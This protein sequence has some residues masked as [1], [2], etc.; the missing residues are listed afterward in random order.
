MLRIAVGFAV[1][2]I[3]WS[4]FIHMLGYFS[5]RDFWF[6]YVDS[7]KAASIYIK[8]QRRGPW[9]SLSALYFPLEG[10]NY[11]AFFYHSTKFCFTWKFYWGDILLKYLDEK[12]GD[13]FQSPEKHTRNAPFDNY[14]TLTSMFWIC[15]L[16]SSLMSNQIWR[17][18]CL[19]NYF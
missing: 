10:S 2:W 7:E 16:A 8:V 14:F 4:I 6:K 9:W 19:Y 12:I 1:Q 18:L 3:I 17:V 11:P 13:L 15:Q 5:E